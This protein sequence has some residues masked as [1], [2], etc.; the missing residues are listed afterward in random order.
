[1]VNDPGM[2]SANM[3]LATVKVEVKEGEKDPIAELDDGEHIE[4]RLVPLKDLYSLLQ[5]FSKTRG[6]AVDARLYHL[7]WGIE[8]AKKYQL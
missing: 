8:V 7:A 5:E 6:Y 3:A 1:M 4:T 2:S